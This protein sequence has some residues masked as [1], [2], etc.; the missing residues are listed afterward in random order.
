MQTIAHRYIFKFLPFA[1]AHNSTLERA[2]RKDV[3][4]TTTY[5]LKYKHK[6]KCKYKNKCKYKYKYK[7]KYKNKYKY[8]Y[9]NKYKYKYKY[10]EH[11]LTQSTHVGGGKILTAKFWNVYKLKRG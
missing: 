4:V 1:L 11:F 6:H 3:I 5:H 10:T 8:K 7:N 2:L 9:K